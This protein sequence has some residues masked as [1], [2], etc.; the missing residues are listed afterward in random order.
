MTE[1]H[2]GNIYMGIANWPLAF[3]PGNNWDSACFHPSNALNPLFFTSDCLST[4]SNKKGGWIEFIIDL[5]KRNIYART[6]KN[7]KED[8]R[9]WINFDKSK[10]HSVGKNMQ[11]FKVYPIPTSVKTVVPAMSTR[12]NNRCKIE[13]IDANIG[14]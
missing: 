4:G 7:Q 10:D 12:S 14:F 1:Y 8:G 13:L 6:G 2:E 9:G 3:E 5:N 11:T